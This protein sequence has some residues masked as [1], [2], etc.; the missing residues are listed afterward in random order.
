[1]K[2]GLKWLL[3]A[4]VLKLLLAAGLTVGV[5]YGLGS[6]E[7]KQRIE[8]QASAALGHAVVL[9]QVRVSLW[10]L[11][12]A[13]QGV[14]VQTQPP[15]LLARLELGP[16]WS[17]LLHGRLEFASLHLQGAVLPAQAIEALQAG[18]TKNSDAS[19]M[20]A[21]GLPRRLVLE[22][23]VWLDVKGATLTLDV[24]AQLGAYG[25]PHDGDLEIRRGLLEG[26]KLQV[27]QQNQGWDFLLKLAGGNIKGS[28]QYLP[29]AYPGAP[30]ELKAQA[31]TREVELAALLSSLGSASSGQLVLSGRLHASTVISAR[32]S[33]FAGLSHA[34]QSHSS[35]TV[36]QAQLHSM[37]LAKAVKTVG[38][39]RGGETRLDV[40][41]GQLHSRG[42]SLEFTN[43]VASSGILSATGGVAISAGQA[44]SG[45][46]NVDLL[47]APG[48][49]LPL[50]LSGTVIAPELTLTRGALVGAAIGTVLL[51]GVGTG[52]GASVGDKM[53][54]EIKKFFRK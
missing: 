50:V 19:P 25:F 5:H 40:L 14:E 39:S 15:L 17:A 35:F 3:G 49:G 23:V 11:G 10:P 52:A 38:L 31:E 42:K 44:L 1:M 22:D 48:V 6:K 13:L 9:S 43:L 29:A 46:I 8:Q 34:V 32:A 2:R 33:N 45:R 21:F 51:P 26:A 37:D 41:A 36:R 24:Q 53:G 4:L 16:T 54:E 28:L 20:L 30:F 18:L 47:S 12:V 27:R 7:L